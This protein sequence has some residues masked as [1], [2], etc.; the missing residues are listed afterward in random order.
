MEMLLGHG[1]GLVFS[2]MAGQGST[3]HLPQ[4]ELTSPTLRQAKSGALEQIPLLDHETSLGVTLTNFIQLPNVR[5]THVQGF[6]M[7]KTKHVMA[8]LG[9]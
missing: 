5:I 6:D 4:K 7:F 8:K 2:K 9:D 3:M 1:I